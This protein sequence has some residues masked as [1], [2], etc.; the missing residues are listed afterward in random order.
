MKKKR[1]LLIGFALLLFILRESISKIF[2][3]LLLSATLAYLF[4]PISAFFEKKCR[5]SPR[6]SSLSSL[7]LVVLTLFLL[8][9]FGVPAFGRQMRS[10]S[11]TLP[12]M[13]AS[14]QALSDRAFEKLLKIGFSEKLVMDMKTRLSSLATELAGGLFSALP[15]VFGGIGN[16]SYLLLSPVVAFFLIKDRKALFSE[17][18]KLVPLKIRRETMKVFFSV[19]TALGSYVRGQLLVSFLTGIMTSVGLF[20]IRMPFALVLGL[21]MA[22]FDL[23]PYFGP[24]LGAV[25]IVLLSLTG[26]LP[27]ALLSVL[28]VFIAQQTEALVL[29]P[30]ILGDAAELH[31]CV[32]LLAL[33]FASFL[34]GL[35]GMLYAIPLLLVLRAIFFSLRENRLQE[36]AQ[37]PISADAME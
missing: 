17:A 22:V 15:Q 34:W 26:G 27:S 30:N 8:L 7:L 35:L 12:D 19:Q 25:P 33:L 20:L 5:L 10:L 18:L 28:V 4:C 9:F 23:I 21:L 3:L 36:L 37:N 29:A 31:P 24:W 14:I 16:K 13:I 1:L 32:V 2:I 6:L 11:G